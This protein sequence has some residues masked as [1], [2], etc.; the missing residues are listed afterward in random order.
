[1]P[2]VALFISTVKSLYLAMDDLEIPVN[3]QID[4]ERRISLL[5]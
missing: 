3:Q 5:H 4:K 2:S 1:M